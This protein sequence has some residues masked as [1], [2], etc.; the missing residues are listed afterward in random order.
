MWLLLSHEKWNN[1]TCSNIDRDYYI[2]LCDYYTMW[3]LYYV[4]IILCELKSNRERQ[5][6]MVSVTCGICLDY[7]CLIII[8]WLY[9]CLIIQRNAYTKQSRLTKKTN[10]WLP[11]GRGN[12]G[13]KIKAMRL[14]DTNCCIENRQTR[15]YRELCSLSCN[16]L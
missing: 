16:N 14:T 11:K 7:Y 6:C 12:G 2:I 10:L 13:E 8:L 15:N 4:I 9:Y 5:Y 3:L 1:A